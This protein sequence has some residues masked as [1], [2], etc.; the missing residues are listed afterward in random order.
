MEVIDSTTKR[1]RT[2]Q[3]D[4][5]GALLI[6]GSVSTSGGGDATAA[7][8]A[9]EIAK[10]TSIDNKMSVGVG[11]EYETVAASQTDQVMGGAGAIGD[12]LE[13]ILCVVS[14]A[15][16]SQVQ[17]KDGAGTAITILPNNVGAGVGS[18]YVPLGLISV[19]GAWKVTTAAGVTAIATGNFT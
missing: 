3:T 4:T 12:Y 2:L 7:N 19:G 8:Q 17:I 18:Y 15:A 1:R 6:S 10:L 5:N 16:T 13:G 11:G 14:T 9:T